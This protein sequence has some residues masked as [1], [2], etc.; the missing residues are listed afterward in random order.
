MDVDQSFRSEHR[1]DVAGADI[2]VSVEAYNKKI[3]CLDPYL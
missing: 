1:V 2:I 3:A